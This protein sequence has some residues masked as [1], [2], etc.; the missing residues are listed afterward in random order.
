MFPIKLFTTALIG[1]Q[2]FEY[3]VPFMGGALLGF[4]LSDLLN[5]FETTETKGKTPPE[6]DDDDWNYQ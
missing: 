6:S 1:V 4:L 2:M 5:W 3:V